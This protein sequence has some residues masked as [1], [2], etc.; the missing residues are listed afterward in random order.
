MNVAVNTEL[1]HCYKN[2]NKKRKIM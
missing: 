1:Y 2:T